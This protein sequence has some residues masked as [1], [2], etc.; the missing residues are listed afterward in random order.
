MSYIVKKR[1]IYNRPSGE[2]IQATSE[3][4]NQL[5]GKQSKKS[6]SAEGRLDANFNKKIGGK[7]I[8]NRVQLE[9]NIKPQS[10]EQ[11]MVSIIA[12]PV[13]PLG[14]KLGFGVQG[15]P[16]RVVVDTFL[17]NLTTQTAG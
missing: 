10:T 11:C 14:N 16:G 7:P 1:K 9:V 12:Y 17:K 8:N 4:I 15:D 6:K 3:I 5:G 2:V 13:D